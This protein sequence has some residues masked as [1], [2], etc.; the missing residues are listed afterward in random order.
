MKTSQ[1]LFDGLILDLIDRENKLKDGYI[2]AWLTAEFGSVEAGLEH[3]DDLVLVR[4]DPE[5]ITCNDKTNTYEY[6][7]AYEIRYK[8]DEERSYEP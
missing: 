6:V 3:I 7:T 5:L 1:D 4:T 8:T 2:R